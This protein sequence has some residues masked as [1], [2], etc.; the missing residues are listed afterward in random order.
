MRLDAVP[1]GRQAIAAVVAIAALA[2]AAS[3]ATTVS[4]ATPSVS[5]QE[6]GDPEA[7]E[8]IY[9]SDCAMCHGRDATGMMGM[10]PALR[11]AIDRLTREGVE[12]TIRNGRDTN[13]PMPAF[14]DRL[15]GEQIADVVAYLAALPEGPR[16]F[17][18]DHPSG[19]GDGMM[20]G[21]M[22]RGAP[23]M[24][25]LVILLTAALAGLVGYLIGSSR[26]RRR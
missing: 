26:A 23:W 6:R 20:D 7:G 3:L 16:N 9:R 13:P 19:M 4:L 8:R 22:G 14:G 15:N 21:M 2:T 25:V 1:F 11:G 12:V 24:V 5:A 10:H 18:P 17:G